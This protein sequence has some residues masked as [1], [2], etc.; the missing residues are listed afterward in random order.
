MA[1]LRSLRRQAVIHSRAMR[2]V[3]AA[4]ALLTLAACA[5]VATAAAPQQQYVDSGGKLRVALAKQPL[6]PTGRST[7]PNT[8][9][10]GGIQKILADMGAVVRIDEA[11]LTPEE[12]KEYG[13]W[14]RLGMSL[15]HFADIV[16]K[17]ERGG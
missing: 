7:G 1:G 6:S 13:G 8:M 17:N 10:E 3:R 4:A 14:K 12:D 9:A 5:V 11:K 16:S 2:R 15:G